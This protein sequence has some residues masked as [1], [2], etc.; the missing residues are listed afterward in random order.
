MRSGWFSLRTLSV[1]AVLGALVLTAAPPAA[2]Q[3]AG[4]Q[5]GPNAILDNTYVGSIDIPAGG[6]TVANAGTLTVG[7]WFVDKQAQGWAGADDV[8]VFLGSMGS[9]GTML[10]KGIV[11]QNRPDVGAA[12]GNAF[13]AASGFSASVQGSA[14]PT[15]QQTLN[16]YLH[17][18]GKG[19]WFK[20]VNVNVSS[21]APAAGMPAPSTSSTTTSGGSA[22]TSVTVTAPNEAQNVSTRSSFT[23]QGTASSDVDRVDVWINGEPETGTQLGTVT[24]ASDGSWSLSFNPTR[25]PSTHSNLYVFAHSKVTGKSVETIRGFNITDKSV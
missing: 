9:G 21:T 22:N 5:Q 7:G 12:L 14:L 4:W 6:S 20:S 18:P 16:V 19:W 3:P 2:A 15:G 8:Q 25:F 11:G 10:A 13:W 17:T 1:F 24:P 23:I